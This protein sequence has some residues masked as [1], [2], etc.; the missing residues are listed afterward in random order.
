MDRRRLSLLAGLMG[1]GVAS[2]AIAPP[3]QAAD[4]E[5]QHQTSQGV[6]AITISGEMV[7]ADGEAFSKAAATVGQAVVVFSSPGGSLFAGLQI[8]QLIQLHHFATA[9]LQGDYCASACAFAWLAGAPRMIEDGG[10]VG[11]HAAYVEQG[12]AK[13]ESGV[14]NALVGAY[15]N[16]LGMSADTIIYM[17]MAQPD[18]ITWLTQA[19]AQRLGLDVKFFA[20]PPDGSPAEETSP[21]PPAMT[22]N[23]PAT[24][25]PRMA[26]ILL[27]ELTA[28]LPPPSVAVSVET[29]ARSFINTYFAQ[30]SEANAQA[31]GY[32]DSTYAAHVIFYGSTI[33][34]DAL[35]ASKQRFAARWPSRIY[36]ARADTLAI[37]C[38]DASLI[39]TVSGIVDWDC[40]SPARDKTSAGS[41]NFRITVALNGP[42]PIIL[43]ESGSVISRSQ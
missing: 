18:Q 9:V 15:L 39:C 43:A 23:P 1:I 19:D 41:A 25:D 8:G 13:V 17:E 26:S 10:Q 5:V 32:F 36:N 33:D 35:M 7:L 31:L 24:P 12:S 3:L 20:P 30:W 11:F 14:G 21:T 37:F 6:S 29:R 4:I 38:N 2:P 16:T 40:K 42:A 28:P 27:P 34:H 22:A